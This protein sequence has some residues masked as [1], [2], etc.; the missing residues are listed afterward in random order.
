MISKD[1]KLVKKAQ[2]L[3]KKKYREIEGLFLAEGIRFVEAAI[4]NGSAEYVLYSNM[5]YSTNGY[6]RVLESDVDS[7]EVQ[8]SILR[9]ICDTESPQGVVAICTKKDH[10]IEEIMG[11]LLVI[12]DGVQDPGNLGT[13]IRTCDAAGVSGII[14][15]KGTVDVY[16]PK[17]LR[18]TM[19]SIFHIPIVSADNFSN[20][21]NI[22]LNNG[23]KI[24]ATS[25]Q[26]K[27]S[28]YEY[29]FSNKTAVILGN[30]ANGVSD[31]NL[32]LATDLIII[33]MEGEAESLN[34]GV[35]NSV[36]VYEALRQ[37]IYKK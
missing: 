3:K 30:E 26:G 32:S 24:L 27:K 35:A 19:G 37:R 6:E 4:E 7:F 18:S 31:E 36:I 22:L 21:S 20:T 5:I 8:D 15:L 23:Y 28:L 17:V 2:K 12:V 1:N 16:N 33:P 14:I 29:N 13:I 11:D 25:L 34:V 9:D 10:V